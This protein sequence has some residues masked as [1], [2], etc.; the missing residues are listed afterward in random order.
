MKKYLLFSMIAVVGASCSE[1]LTLQPENQISE[2]SF[3]KN[4]NDFDAALS[5]T[6]AE[7]Q[8]L[9]DAAIVYV[10]DLTT[11]NAEIKWTVPAVAETEFD[12]MN[13]TPAN[14]FLNTIWMS[15]YKV[16]SRSNTILSLL[17]NSGLTGSQKDRLRGECLFLRGY[18]YFYLV[19]IFGAVPLVEVAFRSPNEI[20]NFDMSR[21]E[22]AL[23]YGLIERDLTDAA[24][25]LT[26][27]TGL[28]KSR[29]SAGASETLLGKVYL[30]TKQFDKAAAILKR[31]IDSN[32]YA[33]QP[34][35]GT[36]FTNG[37]DNLKESV[38][39][40]LYMSG[41]VGEGNSFSSIFTPAR[42]DMAIFPGNMQGSGRIVPTPEIAAAYENGDKRRPVSVRDSIRTN[43]GKYEKDLFGLKFVDFTTGIVGDGGINFTSLRYAD[44]LMMYGESLNELGQTGPAHEYLNAVRIR[45][46]LP[47]V[48]GLS[49][50]EFRLAMEMERR[51]EFFLEGHRW[52]DLV[53]TNRAETVLNDYFR[54]KGLSFTVA[55]HELIMPIP[56]REIDIN[57]NLGQNQGY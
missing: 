50:S 24:A 23:V 44:V 43:T 27:V 9:H 56:I 26:G 21:K 38:F 47:G 48:S 30:T 18:S 40:I 7:L 17:D 31:V 3:Y 55:P 35:Y 54:S 16:I 11:D 20:M 1:F 32:T 42:F 6:Y 33:L 41:N 57:P 19:R 2:N 29:A 39:E 15:S 36:L 12:E 37:N 8:T 25:L 22:P 49:Q 51:L 14:S 52:F 10:G 45:A 4:I 53:R 46:G 28:A 13:P 5:G 34:E